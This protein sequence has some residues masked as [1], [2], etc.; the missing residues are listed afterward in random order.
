MVRCNF[1]AGA[2]WGM[3][4]GES[5]PASSPSNLIF[6]QRSLFLHL[7]GVLSLWDGLGINRGQFEFPRRLIVLAFRCL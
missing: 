4:A 7:L 2:P 6:F 5:L 1:V 3:G